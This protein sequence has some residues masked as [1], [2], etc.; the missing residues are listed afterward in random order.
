MRVTVCQLSDQR[1]EFETG[2]REL[3][4]HVRAQNSDL[5]LLPEMP[6]SDWFAA[7][8]EFDAEVWDAAVT[9]HRMWK[10]RLVELSPATVI[11]TE[12]LVIGGCRLNEAY[13][14]NGGRATPLHQ[15]RYLPNEDGF[16]EARWYEPS[17]G[18]FDLTTLADASIGVQICTELWWLDESRNYGRSGADVLLAPRATPASSRERWLVAGQGAAILAGA[19]C[20][21]SNRSGKHRTGREFAGLGWII[22]PEGEVLARTSDTQRCVT[23]EID[24]AR[25]REAKRTYPR[26][27]R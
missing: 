16:W 5:V 4:A 2:W 20:L 12:P 23:A 18:A 19:Y 9:Q 26:Y 13:A 10:Q 25:A 24:L 3:C 21:S 1:R 14:W 7:D 15:K 27:V 17:T 8:P 6:F 11:S 22:D